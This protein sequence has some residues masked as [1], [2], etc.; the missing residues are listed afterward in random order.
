MKAYAATGAHPGSLPNSGVFA[1]HNSIATPALLPDGIDLE[2]SVSRDAR[3]A[4]R[5]PWIHRQLSRVT[6]EAFAA[7]ERCQGR[8]GREL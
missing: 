7:I 2:A 4:R 5:D 3:R 8:G 6:A 1:R